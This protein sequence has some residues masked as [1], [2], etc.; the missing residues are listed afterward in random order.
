MAIFFL[1]NGIVFIFHKSQVI[2]I[3]TFIV[4]IIIIITKIQILRFSNLLL[5]AASHHKQTSSL[6]LLITCG[7]HRF[8][9][10]LLRSKSTIVFFFKRSC[11]LGN[12]ISIATA[13][14]VF[15]Q[16]PGVTIVGNIVIAQS[17][18]IKIL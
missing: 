2:L 13:S 4:G 16:F 10:I 18:L 3:G 11:I 12:T 17:Q 5:T 15:H 14:P 7:L 8:F 9:E 1:Q 6:E